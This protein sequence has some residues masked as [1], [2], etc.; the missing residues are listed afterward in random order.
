M[1]QMA[2]DKKTAGEQ[3]LEGRVATLDAELTSLANRVSILMSTIGL[4]GG[5]ALLDKAGTYERYTALLKNK[6]DA[7]AI[8]DDVADLEARADDVKDK[9]SQ[10]ENEVSGAQ[11]S[12]LLEKSRIALHES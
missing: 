4:S 7:T 5:A 1:L 3:P 8:Q 9:I 12:S 10:V 6:H 2:A 11:L